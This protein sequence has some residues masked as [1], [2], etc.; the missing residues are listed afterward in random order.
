MNWKFRNMPCLKCCFW[1]LLI[2][3]HGGC[4]T[5]SQWCDVKWKLWIAEREGMNERCRCSSKL[6]GVI[7]FLA[8]PLSDMKLLPMMSTVCIMWYVTVCIVR[9]NKHFQIL[10]TSVRFISSAESEIFRRLFLPYAVAP[11]R[12]VCMDGRIRKI[13]VTLNTVL[14]QHLHSV[15]AGLSYNA[16][17]TIPISTAAK[18][19]FFVGLCILW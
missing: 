16:W 6:G 3:C 8:F 13:N 4:T 11:S 15:S 14:C 17:Y 5:W 1:R 10:M 9:T 2:H 19:H 12:V 7:V 18:D